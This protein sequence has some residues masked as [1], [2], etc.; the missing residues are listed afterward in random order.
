MGV[1]I[2]NYQLYATIFVLFIH[3]FIYTIINNLSSFIS[4]WFR[5]ETEEAHLQEVID[6]LLNLAIFVYFGAIIPW[7]TFFGS[8]NDINLWK[9]FLCS[10]MVLL[11]RRLPSILALMY[12]IPAIKTY[13]E[14]VFTG[15]FGNHCCVV[16]Y[17]LYFTYKILINHSLFFFFLKG[18]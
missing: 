4:D 5:R 13:R 10:V 8:T 14:A 1:S 18:P 3:L 17:N 6:M 9:L 15:W 16:I 12:I 2:T 7:S 11:F